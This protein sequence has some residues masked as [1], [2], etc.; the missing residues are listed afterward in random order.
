MFDSDKMRQPYHK[1]RTHPRRDLVLRYLEIV[2]AIAVIVFA[3][4][5]VF[6]VSPNLVA[7]SKYATR[8]DPVKNAYFVFSLLFGFFLVSAPAM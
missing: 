3:L 1:Y 2:V 8:P 5:Y 7:S 4:P 6:R